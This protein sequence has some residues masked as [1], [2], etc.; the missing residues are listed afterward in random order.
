MLVLFGVCLISVSGIFPPIDD[1]ST[2]YNESD[3][4]V[5]LAAQMRISFV[6]KINLVRNTARFTTIC[7]RQPAVWDSDTT[8]CDAAAAKPA[9]RVSHSRLDLLCTLLC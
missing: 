3:F 4:P 5:N 2:A 6:T 9:V 7:R 1:P 8:V